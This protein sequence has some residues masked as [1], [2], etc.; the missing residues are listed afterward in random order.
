M[1]EQRIQGLGVSAGTRIGRVHLYRPQAA[2]DSLSRK[3]VAEADVPAEL[4]R[5]RAAKE[6]SLEQLQALVE[7]TKQSLGADKAVILEGQTSIL[8]DPTFFPEMEKRIQGQLVS[9]ELA[10]DQVVEQIAGL[11]ES[12]PQEYM[13]ERAADVRDVG[14]RLRTNLGGNSGVSLADIQ[15]EVVLV[16]DDLTPSD[17][18]QLDKTY[19]L[20]IVTRTGGKTSHTAILAKS[21]GIPAV[22]GIGAALDTIEQGDLL[23]LDG[24][25]GACVL[26]PLESTVEEA[27]RRME[28]EHHQS[29]ALS[30][31]ANQ[32]AVTRDGHQIEVVANIGTTLESRS[33]LA[34]GA[35]GIGLFRTEFLF[36][37]A[38]SMPTEEEQF[39]AYR[40]VAENLQGHPVVIRTLDIGGDKELPYLELPKELNPFLG[41]R[42]I[43]LCLD[44]P[45]IL[46]TQLRAIL[47]ASV[48]GQLKVMFP[49]ISNLQEWRQAKALW[50]QAQ[51]QLRAEGVAFADGIEVGMMV[52]IPSAALLADQFAKEVDFFSI[53]TNDLVQYTVAVDRMNEKVADL[54]DYF[55]PAVLRLIQ[56]VIEAGHREGKWTGMCGGMAGD[57][58]ATPLLLGLGLDEWS[59][60]AGSIA[61]IKHAVHGLHRADCVALAQRLLTLGTA[62]EIRT[63]LQTYLQQPE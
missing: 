17:T 42:A 41:Y 37:N 50:L 62:P 14:K 12:L 4:E 32:P 3:Q 25:T 54:Y 5:L 63:E 57:P 31:Y 19:I 2:T 49:M 39:A 33:S 22:L 36:M 30:V 7:K 28:D 48:H 53:G 43:R 26:H 11:F 6:Q 24:N 20:G 15:Q 1:S 40:E 34:E 35:E 55:H 52:E 60:D 46:L 58:Q 59:M 38:T 9:A 45:E 56:M 51:E 27:R 10:V 44:R 16:A 21:L 8:A 47:R 18:V 23:L 29:Q 13:R 61:K